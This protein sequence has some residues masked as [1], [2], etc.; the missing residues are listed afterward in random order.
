MD[1]S[2]GASVNN[3]NSFANGADVPFIFRNGEFLLFRQMQ[4]TV[5]FWDVMA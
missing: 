1:D 5:T 3:G 4:V 2:R